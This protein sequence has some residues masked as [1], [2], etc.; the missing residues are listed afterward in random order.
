MSFSFG[1]VNL[2]EFICLVSLGAALSVCRAWQWFSEHDWWVRANSVF[3]VLRTFPSV[4]G[5]QVLPGGEG[6]KSH[7]FQLVLQV[8]YISTCVCSWVI[9]I[10]VSEHLCV[11]FNKTNEN[12][13]WSRQ[14]RGTEVERM[15]QEMCVTHWGC[16]SAWT[17]AQAAGPFCLLWLGK[18]RW[19][20]VV[21]HPGRGTEL[22]ETDGKF[23]LYYSRRV[24]T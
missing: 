3:L 2:F 19:W 5:I 10:A 24:K 8:S 6:K 20:L 9:F 23:S 15:L 16:K 4:C 18:I 13:N 21:T 22:E 1:V 14:W 12:T 7:F 17:A 11:Y